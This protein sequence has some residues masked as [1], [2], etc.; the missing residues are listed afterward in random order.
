MFSPQSVTLRLKRPRNV[1]R[2]E[3]LSISVDGTAELGPD[4][5]PAGDSDSSKR[6]RLTGPGKRLFRLID[7][8]PEQPNKR[9]CEITWKTK[10]NHTNHN[11]KQEE[12]KN[13]EIVNVINTHQSQ[14]QSHLSGSCVVSTVK[15]KSR[16]VSTTP[17]QF[18]SQMQRIRAAPPAEQMK[19]YEA[20]VADYLSTLSDEK[21]SEAESLAAQP[22]AQP[23][24]PKQWTEIPTAPNLMRGANGPSASVVSESESD[25]ADYEYDYYRIILNPSDSDWSSCTAPSL[26]LD[27]REWEAL[28]LNETELTDSDQDSEDENREDHENNDYPEEESEDEDGEDGYGYGDQDSEDE[29]EEQVRGLGRQFKSWRMKEETYRDRDEEEDDEYLY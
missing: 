9:I 18:D 17:Q 1:A 8:E 7:S 13:N 11:H 6:I 15:R 22:I 26:V 12:G 5:P 10:S 2:P 19:A 28:L 3:Y 21:R 23:P 24:Q 27:Q 20:L 14:S 29:E 16:A 25:S 4:S